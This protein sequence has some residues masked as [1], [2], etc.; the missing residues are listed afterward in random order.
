MII[1]HTKYSRGHKL[2]SCTR[3]LFYTNHIMLKLFLNTPLKYFFVNCSRITFGYS[4][5]LTGSL[6]NTV[7]QIIVKDIILYYYGYLYLLQNEYFLHVLML[8]IVLL[9]KLTTTKSERD[10]DK[11]KIILIKVIGNTKM[12]I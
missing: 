2:I 1:D 11:N 12:D 6:H 7:L 3:F 9:I 5:Q 4:R 8:I 10:I